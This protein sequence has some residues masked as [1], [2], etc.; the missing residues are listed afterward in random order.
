MASKDGEKAE[1]LRLREELNKSRMEKELLRWE[2][3]QVEAKL[4]GLE[5]TMDNLDLGDLGEGKTPT[6]QEGNV[7]KSH[8][9]A[10]DSEVRFKV[11]RSMA[12]SQEETSGY[13]SHDSMVHGMRDRD[14][15]TLY[16]TPQLRMSTPLAPKMRQEPASYRG[17]PFRLPSTTEQEPMIQLQEPLHRTS[18]HERGATT[19]VRATNERPVMMPDRYNGKTPWQDYHQHFEA[20]REVNRWDDKQAAS[21][22]AAS[23]QE[24]AMR[25][26]CEI[27]PEQRNSYCELVRL[28]DRRFG[29]GQQAENYLAELRHRRQGQRESL[30]EL[31]QAIHE[32]AIRAY[33]EIPASSRNRLEKNHFIDAVENQSIREGIHRARPASLDEAIQAALETENFERVEFQRRGE[34]MR[35]GKFVRALNH[36][37]ETRFQMVEQM[38]FQQSN[39]MEILTQF[40]RGKQERTPS[41]GNVTATQNQAQTAPMSE[42]KCYNCGKPGHIIR[43]CPEPR[44]E[45]YRQ[46]GNGNQPNRGSLEGLQ[47]VQGPPTQTSPQPHA[48]Q[49]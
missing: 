46:R 36:E 18:G 2:K 3:A 25:A 13:L 38:L 43:Q 7:G 11:P 40:L 45:R 4:D 32:L 1:V 8:Y 14:Y 47:K 34:R 6:W 39:Q 16:P 44:K 10:M 5:G 49:Q 19:S 29:P 41:Q 42:L 31:G 12:T 30:Q 26:I 20:C 37:T 9:K 22:L 48:T 35:Q 17:K 15:S 33:P 28:L 27:L 23:L 24:S 21:F